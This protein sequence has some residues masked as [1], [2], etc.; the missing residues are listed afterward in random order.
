MRIIATGTKFI[1]RRLILALVG[2]EFE[3]VCPSDLVEVITL[4]KQGKFDLVVVDSLAKGVETT[5]RRIRE[6]GSVPIVLM[7]GQERPDWK[8]MQS[9]DING[10]IPRGVN[11]AELVAR[12]RAVLRRFWPANELKNEPCARA[13]KNFNKILAPVLQAVNSNILK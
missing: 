6:V 3:L 7:V 1:T 10:Y 9:L 12:L 13:P 8:E 2:S 4:L 11:E 5:C